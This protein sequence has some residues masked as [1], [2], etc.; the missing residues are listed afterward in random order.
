MTTLDK[1]NV[2]ENLQFVY[3]FR[4]SL[5]TTIHHCYHETP[6]HEY[7]HRTQGNGDWTDLYRRKP[8]VGLHAWVHIKTSVQWTSH[9]ASTLGLLAAWNQWTLAT[10]SL[11]V[12]SLLEASTSAQTVQ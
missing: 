4:V 8:G 12:S 10:L 7:R 5:P 1:G 11:V 6:V 3:P 2:Q 9:A